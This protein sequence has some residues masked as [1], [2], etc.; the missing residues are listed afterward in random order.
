MEP[1]SSAVFTREEVEKHNEDGD[2]W[3]I[4]DGIVYDVSK[5]IYKHP[6]GYKQIKCMAG[7]DCSEVFKTFHNEKIS[8]N[9]LPAFRVG[10]ITANASNKVEGGGKT[11]IAKDLE[12]LREDL[13][14][15][16]AF[17]PDCK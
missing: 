1:K 2:I 6:G 4:I 11:E 17:E 14:K 5:W 12:K 3:L 13:K 10:R 7:K 8:R 15:E 9:M 16:G